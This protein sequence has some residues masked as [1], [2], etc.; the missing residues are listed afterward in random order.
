MSSAAARWRRSA[1]PA[2]I[3]MM[4]KKSMEA[5]SLRA[6]LET[7][8]R[9]AMR[10]RDAP[11]R[12]ALRFLLSAVKN[13]EIEKRQP[14]TEQEEV[15]LLRQQA[16]QRQEA[17]EQFQAG[18]RTDL[19]ERERAQLAI[20]DG[21]LPQQMSD[22][23][24]AQ[25]VHKGIAETGASSPKEMGKVMGVLSKRAEGRVDGRRLSDA[26]RKALAS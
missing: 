1:D 26:V 11:R 24:L 13:A 5:T 8:L 23:E 17:I 9:Q 6:R 2:L 25:F 22:D 15:A 10:D 18:G 4:G 16:R 3:R 19:E 12:D 21:Y 20:I 14:L 7:D